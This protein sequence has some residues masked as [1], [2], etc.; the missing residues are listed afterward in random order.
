MRGKGTAATNKYEFQTIP[1]SGENILRVV[2]VDHSG[3]KRASDEVKFTS[4]QKS[5]TKGSTIVKSSI[6]FTEENQP[7]STRFE[8]YDVYG[9][10]IKKGTGS[11]V[12]CNN[13]L[14][15]AY[16][17]NYDNKTEKFFKN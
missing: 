11:S 3:N 7:S 9:N 2:Q 13:L 1:H 17:I 5:I 4:Q 14:K 15:G 10:I 16:Y 12:D 8:I 6:Y